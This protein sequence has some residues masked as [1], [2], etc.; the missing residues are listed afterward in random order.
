MSGDDAPSERRTSSADIRDIARCYHALDTRVAVLETRI[1]GQDQRLSAIEADVR[2]IKS[3]IEKVLDT[4]GAHTRQE[5][6][7][8][9]KLMASVIA[10]LVSAVGALA[11]LL[12]QKIAP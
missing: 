2:E 6:R 9:F 4:L 7:D 10:T 8:R 12:Y 11:L 5:D 3:G 1:D